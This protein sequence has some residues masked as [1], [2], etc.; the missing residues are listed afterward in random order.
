MEDANY[1]AVANVFIK[2]NCNPASSAAVETF[3]CT[4][5]SFNC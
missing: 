1:P 2:L 5:T 3:Q 4:C